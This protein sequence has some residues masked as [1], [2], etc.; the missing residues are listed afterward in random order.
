MA[1]QNADHTV[2]SYSTVVREYPTLFANVRRFST[3]IPALQADFA[4]ARRLIHPIATDAEFWAGK[5]PVLYILTDVE[6]P[7]GCV[8]GGVNLLASGTKHCVYEVFYLGLLSSP[9]LK[10]DSTHEP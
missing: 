4:L 9:P 6:D 8:D 2:G 3:V 10:K 7:A 5:T 1:V